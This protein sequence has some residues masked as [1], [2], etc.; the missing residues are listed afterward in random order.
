MLPKKRGFYMNRSGSYITQLAGYKA[1]IPA[2]LP[3][4]P[5]IKI[6]ENL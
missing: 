6:D 3:P 4:Q 5:A 2:P 1:F